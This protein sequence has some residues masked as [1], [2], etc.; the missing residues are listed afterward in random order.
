MSLDPPIF[1]AQFITKLFSYKLI[2]K[3]VSLQLF[4][5]QITILL[6][7]N[8]AGKTTLVQ[9]LSG[10]LKPSSGKLYL[11]GEDISHNF[12]KLRMQLGTIS[13]QVHL[14]PEMDG[15]ENLDFFC[16]LWKIKDRKR[17]IESALSDVHLHSYFSIPIKSYS[18]GMKKRLCLAKLMVIEPK[19]L[20]LDEPYSG[21]DQK[22]VS[23]L[24]EF[25]LNF[26]N[27]GNTILMITHQFEH[28]TEIGDQYLILHKNQLHQLDRQNHESI[29]NTYE[30][31]TNQ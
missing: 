14:Y 30:S 21:L 5:N 26:K 6:G 16:S 12:K 27:Q 9:I 20:F 25:L 18:S 23:L 10:I 29:K 4:Q 19:I 28:A 13:H 2:I 22:S 8:G 1:E 17:K 7:N 24:N 15:R 3:N 11:Q 31:L